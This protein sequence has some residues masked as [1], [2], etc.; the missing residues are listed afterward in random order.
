MLKYFQ[1]FLFVTI[2]QISANIIFALFT[3]FLNFDLLQIVSNYNLAFIIQNFIIVLFYFLLTIGWGLYFKN[4]YKYSSKA[5]IL[6]AVLLIAYLVTFYLSISNMNYFKYFFYIHYP[7]GSFYRTVIA[8]LFSL[9][10]K[11]SLIVSIISACFGV[12]I[13]HRVIVLRYKIKKKKLSSSK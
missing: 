6:G 7:I 12:Y 10:L 9:T 11:I 8:S 1:S 4:S 5:R 3:I 13:G 2:I